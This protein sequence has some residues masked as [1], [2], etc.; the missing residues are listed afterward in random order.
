MFP[1]KI[2]HKI[3]LKVA[4]RLGKQCFLLVELMLYTLAGMPVEEVK[5]LDDWG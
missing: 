2:Y 1:E 3:Q 4:G 5:C